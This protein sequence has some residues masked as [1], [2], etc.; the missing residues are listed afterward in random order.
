M[1]NE[2]EDI[3]QKNILDR[4]SARPASLDICLASFVVWYIP[5][6]KKTQTAAQCDSDNEDSPDHNITVTDCGQ[7]WGNGKSI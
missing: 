4:Y 5:V 1:E 3:F 2:D 6:Y 7:L